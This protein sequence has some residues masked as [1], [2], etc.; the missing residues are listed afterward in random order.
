MRDGAGGVSWGKNGVTQKEHLPPTTEGH[1]CAKVLQ[2]TV[3]QL[4]RTARQSGDRETPHYQANEE[5]AGLRFDNG[6]KLPE[7]LK[8]KR[9]YQVIV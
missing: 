2:D 8:E 6:L 4:C 9:G 7:K 1:H 3:K 5:N